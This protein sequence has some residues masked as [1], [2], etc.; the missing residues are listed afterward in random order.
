MHSVPLFPI[1]VVVLGLLGSIIVLGFLRSRIE[2]TLP[3]STVNDPRTLAT[4][5]AQADAARQNRLAT[6]DVMI[7]TTNPVNWPDASLGCPQP[8]RVYGQVITPGFLVILSV[9]GQELE[10]HTGEGESAAEIPV[11]DC[12]D[13]PNKHAGY[14]RSSL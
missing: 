4:V 5:A 14:P 7:M 8:G 1:F 3:I 12:T 13:N 9:S 11:V 2:E 6:A 10:Y